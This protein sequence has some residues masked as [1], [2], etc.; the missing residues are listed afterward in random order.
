MILDSHKFYLDYTNNFLTV[1][2]IA[3]NYEVT[4]GIAHFHINRGR[5]I[6]KL[7]ANTNKRKAK[8]KTKK[9]LL[10]STPESKGKQGICKSIAGYFYAES[11]TMIPMLGRPRQWMVATGKDKK[12]HEGLFVVLT[13]KGRFRFEDHRQ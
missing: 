7:E 4:E 5:E 11:V 6:E 3:S 12:V 9:K 2:G 10:A 8:M 13:T 1:E